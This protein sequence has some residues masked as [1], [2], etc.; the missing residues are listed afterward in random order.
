MRSKKVKKA[1]QQEKPGTTSLAGQELIDSAGKNRRKIGR[2]KNLFWL[3]ASLLATF[4]VF[5]VFLVLVLAKDLPSV[6]ELNERKISQ[7]TKI[8]DRAGQTL[9]YEIHANENRTIIPLSDIPKSLKDATIVTE[10]ENFYTES[11]FSWFAIARALMVNA[12]NGRILQGG[13]TITQQLAK[14][15]FLSSEQT[16]TRKI[17]EFVLAIQLN[18]RY[19]KDEILYFYLNEI[20]Y[21]PTA[22]GVEAASE[23]YFG[24]PVKYLTLAESAVIAALPRAPSYYSPWGSHA[25]ELFSR[26]K[27]ILGRMYRLDKITEKE[28]NNALKEKISFAPR[29]LTGIKAPHFVMTVVDELTQKY[30]EAAV[31]EG[32]L[33]VITTLDW[34]LQRAAEKAVKDGAERNEKLYQGYNASLVAEDPKTGQILALV[35]SRDYFASS[36]LPQ[37]CVP[38]QN[39]K[40]EPN[41]NVAVQGLRQPGSA[42]KPFAYLT[43]FE[44]G[45]SPDTA[46]FDAPTEFVPNNPLCPAAVDFS[47]DNPACFHPE[48]F[49]GRFLGPV[50]LRQALAQS[51]NVASVKVLYLAGLKNTLDTLH[52]FGITTLNE[53]GRYGLSL[54]L[55]GGEVK[56]IDLVEAYSALSQEGVKHQQSMILEVRNSNNQI[57]ESYQDQSEI[58]AGSQFVRLVND[59]LSDN[60]ARAGLFQ[61]SLPLTVFP[62]YDV[63]LKTGTSND[64]R[65]AWAVGYTPS[66]VAGVWAGNNDNAP[67]QKNAG[68]I[69]AAV[70]IW[71]D[72]MLEALKTQPKEVFN[73]PSPVTESKP[74]LNGDYLA[75]QQIHSILYYVDKADPLG[76]APGNPAD[77]PQFSNWEFGVLEWAKNNLPNFSQSNLIILNSTSSAP[78]PASFS[79]LIQIIEPTSAAFVGSPLRVAAKISAASVIKQ[80]N[81]YFNG[82]LV[83]SFSENL[84][85]PYQ[86]DWSFAPTLN[87][88]NLLEVEAIDG[89]GRS[90][91]QEII[92]YAQ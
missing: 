16:L 30:G 27:Y 56:L 41:F 90:S 80:I 6:A 33:K 22:Y 75:N 58:A 38:G 91:R 49:S 18:R 9:L 50:T 72:F 19:S 23:L 76:P 2:W 25:N 13:S 35:G 44:K 65:D 54:V 60:D 20:P 47:N 28:F 36:S 57:L 61:N 37:G 89:L 8:Y 10:D 1:I 63:A 73:R 5:F 66:F 26:Q 39:C 92:L 21:G 45:Y 40:F 79:P 11:G 4:F 64:Y 69:L 17:K 15:A 29:S 70:P 62:D 87:P 86:L 32:G 14:N 31:R 48:N 59:V 53:A 81:V 82:R 34:N 74:M 85:S 84:G 51:I 83:G 43:L 46:L 88:Q 78:A 52:K 77:D 7:S 24:K 12:L 3:A 55:G 42:L 68:S 71:H 67:M